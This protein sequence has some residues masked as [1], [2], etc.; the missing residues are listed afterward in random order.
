[1][2]FLIV[3]MVITKKTK[4]RDERRR[5]Q[6]QVNL[7]EG[8]L[9]TVSIRSPTQ[10][11]S[12]R[13]SSTALTFRRPLTLGDIKLL[14]TGEPLYIP[15]TQDSVPKTEDQL[16]EDTQVLV[17]LGSDALGSELRAKLLSAYLLSDMEAFKAANPGCIL[18]DFIRWCSPRDWIENED[19][20]LDDFGQKKGK[21]K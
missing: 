10:V 20:E 5:Q 13:F 17:K 2:N 4:E 21:L 15:V 14:E 11:H 1:M 3:V 7:W 19:G 6:L 18:A 16:E 8:W 9:N 12:D